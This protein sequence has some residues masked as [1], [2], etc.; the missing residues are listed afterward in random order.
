M[1]MVLVEIEKVSR[2]ENVRSGDVSLAVI[3]YGRKDRALVGAGWKRKGMLLN[4]E[5]SWSFFRDAEELSPER[6]KSH[7]PDLVTDTN[8]ETRGSV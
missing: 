5:F 6:D 7:M 3:I 8:A 4:G 2:N 1:S